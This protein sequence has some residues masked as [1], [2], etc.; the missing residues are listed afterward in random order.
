[1][2]PRGAGAVRATVFGLGL[3]DMPGALGEVCFR[4]LRK[5]EE[6]TVTAEG[7]VLVDRQGNKLAGH[8]DGAAFVVGKAG[9]Q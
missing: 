6:A 4:G 8:V 2:Q 9:A 7:V 5:A 3:D 1:V